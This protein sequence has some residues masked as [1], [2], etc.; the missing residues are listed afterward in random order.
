MSIAPIS[1][2]H[3]ARGIVMLRSLRRCHPSAGI[4]VLALDETCARV[5]RD[6]FDCALRVIETET[7]HRAAPELRSIREQRSAW[8]YYATQKPCLALF[9]MESNPR[10]EAV[11]YIDADTWFLAIRPDVR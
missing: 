5:L 7:L 4:M 9:A 2:R 3:L 8:A 11:I 6:R 1:I 10:P